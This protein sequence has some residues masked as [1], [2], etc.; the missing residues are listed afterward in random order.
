MTQNIPTN[1]E[2]PLAYN[3]YTA[4][5]AQSL[6]QLMQQR[7]TEN[8]VFTDQVFEGSNFNN[9]LDVVAYS[10]NVLLFYLNQTSNE[11]LFSNASIYE[12]MN[13]IVKIINY[14]PVGMQ[15][16]T[17]NFK[18]RANGG[19][20]VGTYT[21]PRFSYFTINDIFYSFPNDVTFVKSTTGTELLQEISDFSLLYQGQFLEYPIYFATGENFEEVSLTL[22]DNNNNNESIDYSNIYVFV[23]DGSGKWKEWK[24]VESIYLENGSSES[25]E[26][27][28]NEKLRYKIKFGNNITGKKQDPGNLIA[29]YYLRTDK[30][31][32]FVGP[33]TLNG[34]SLFLYSTD[35]YNTIMSDV[36]DQRITTISIPVVNNISFSNEN[37]STLFSNIESVSQIKENAP[38][39]YKRQGR[40]VT[41]DDFKSFISA[42]FSNVLLDVNVSSNS[43]Y[44][45]EHLTYLYNIG[46][47]Q[48]Q[49]DSRVLLNQVTF[50]DTC[51]FNNVYVY[52]VPKILQTNDFNFQ[53]CYLNLGLKDQI[54]NKTKAYKMPN[55]NVV[56]Q[57]PVFMGVGFGC[58]TSNE[59]VEKTLETSI[60]D[61]TMFFVKRKENSNISIQEIKNKTKKVI[62]D[63]FSFENSRL[64]QTIDLQFITQKL[65]S[66]DGVDSFYTQRGNTT[67]PGLNLLFFNSVYNSSDEDI[68][69]IS[70]NIKLEFFKIPFWFKQETLEKNIS[71]IS[72]S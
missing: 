14:N 71:I 62:S 20:P 6:K 11:S 2:F 42:N 63:Y 60:I 65:L 44:I 39:F 37:S 24:R 50:S 4:F 22:V 59:I 66:I 43:E 25:Y 19:V 55:V 13:K 45:S 49:L 35:Q 54:I 10:Y 16:C 70:Q 61:E 41:L 27:R 1:Q 9:L 67:M 69:I 17:L 46:L 8:G 3:A 28:L 58:A 23:R 48:P 36:R 53:R 29:I 31:N 52:C 32:G 34:N 26:V 64:G 47:K 33:E 12:N 57:D 68:S 21:I 40:I 38:N 51:N 7:L 15:T 5:D 72:F 30:E 18:A 56:V